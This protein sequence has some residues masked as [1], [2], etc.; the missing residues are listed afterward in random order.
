L[1]I[2]FGAFIR[3]EAELKKYIMACNPKPDLSCKKPVAHT[4]MK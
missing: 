3:D 1:R 2:G 4:F